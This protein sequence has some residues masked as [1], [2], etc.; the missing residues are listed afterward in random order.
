MC[1]PVADPSASPRACG[2]VLAFSFGL[3]ARVLASRRSGVLGLFSVLLLSATVQAAGERLL[4]YKLARDNA[5]VYLLG[6]MHLARADVYPLRSGIMQAFAAA[7]TLAV[8]LDVSE[9]NQ[10]RIQ[11][12]ILARGSYPDGESIRDH[13]SAD[14]WRSLQ[15]YLSGTGLPPHM[16]ES[17]RPGLLIVTLST[18][19][20]M[21]LG[22]S[23]ELGV[24][25]YFLDQARGKKRIHELETIEQQVGLLLDFPHE[26]LLVRQSL[27][28]LDNMGTLMD[29][30]VAVW[31]RGDAPALQ[32]LLLDDELARYPEF[33][34]V[35]ERLFD[36]RNQAMARQVEAF[37]SGSGSY[38]V[39]V[40]AGHLVGE[41]GM[42]ALLRKRGYT[43]RQ[44]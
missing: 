13:L 40:G 30:L 41:Q 36:Q 15:Q 29:E 23:P 38:F 8:E 37:L 4:F 17:M 5:E 9:E 25:R 14:T 34:V 31:K 24:D 43:V 6:S 7:E 12:M 1:I 33:R 28:Q 16:L 2:A 32:K 35:Y 19:E 21:K 11:Q 3:C 22:L 44:L 42:V 10:A 27:A 18:L 39:V 26:D 20:I